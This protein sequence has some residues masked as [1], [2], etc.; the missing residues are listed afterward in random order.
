VQ[1]FVVVESI[2]STN[3]IKFTLLVQVVDGIES[4][5]SHQSQKHDANGTETRSIDVEM[6]RRPVP[7]GCGQH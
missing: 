5:N 3:I 6:A 7:F 4:C 2:L 1:D